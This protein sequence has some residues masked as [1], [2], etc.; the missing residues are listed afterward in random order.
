MKI[1]WHTEKRKISDLIPTDGNP[2]QLTDKQ[3]KDLKK[4]LNKFDLAEIPAINQDNS[5]LA[6]HMRL[7]ILAELKGD[8]EIDVR[9]PNRPLTKKEAEEYLIRSNKNTGEWDM[10]ALSNFD[11]EDLVE[12]GFEDGELGVGD[13]IDRVLVEDSEGDTDN[14]EVFVTSVMQIRNVIA[15]NITQKDGTSGVDAFLKAEQII[16]TVL[17]ENEYYI[18]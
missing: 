2:R 13:S 16:L 15:K 5:I 7:K 11:V 8:H 12:W 18:N 1:M 14:T 17:K 9:V 10:D 3:Y 4:S 6:G